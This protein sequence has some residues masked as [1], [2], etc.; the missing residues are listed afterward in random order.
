MKTKREKRSLW[1]NFLR[2]YTR[3]PIPWWLYIISMAC[4]LLATCITLQLNE[5][6]I[7]INKGELFNR[8]LI[9][10]AVW[11]MIT[12]AVTVVRNMT[13][14]YANQKLIYRARSVL[15]RK[16]LY[17]PLRAFHKEAPYGMVSSI[18]NEVPQAST[19]I[20]MLTLFISSV[21]GFAGSIIV[22]VEYNATLLMY[23]LT[24]IPLAVFQFWAIGKLQFYMNK[25]KFS[26]LNSMTAFFAEHLKCAKQVKANAMEEQEIEAGLKIIDQQFKADLLYGILMSVQT[27]INSVYQTLYTVL[28]AVFGSHMILAGQMSADGILTFRT[29]WTTQD[30]YLSE[31]LAHYQAIKGT[32]GS[33]EKVCDVLAQE[34]EQPNANPEISYTPG[35][36]VLER[37]FFSY[38]PDQPVLENVCCVI[39]YGKTVAVIGGNGS[40][41]TT[42]FKLLIGLYQPQD[43]RIY[44][45]GNETEKQ[46]L[47][48]W[49]KQFGYVSQ[50][51]PLFSGT[52]RDNIHYGISE[53]KSE[54]ELDELCRI[55]NLTEV[56]AEK[57]N[58]LDEELGEAG[59]R[60]SGGQRQRV[61]IA[62]AMAGN[63]AY[64]LLDEATSQLDAVNDRVIEAGV[65]KFMAGKSMIFIAHNMDSARRADQIILLDKGKLIDMGTDAELN[66]RCALYREMVQLQ[67]GGVQHA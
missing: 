32:Q 3:F 58:G 4:G 52:I 30:K 24:L 67:E 62:R 23:M 29:Y 8:V 10:Y 2:F 42:L 34:E 38:E 17:L 9:G 44:L 54:E 55:V 25:R 60:L 15:W 53:N 31:M 18:T 40:G 21:Y 47:S 33:L 26:A 46:N 59:N 37:V 50:S 57:E 64:L 16:I 28:I 66:A 61:A 36:I 48:Q 63:P 11:T 1:K 14:A 39:P 65:T 6:I 22:L 20:D 35:D 27:L 13:T 5:Y 12:A 56:L 51:A 41:K 45:R 7:A 19:T 49:R 43:G